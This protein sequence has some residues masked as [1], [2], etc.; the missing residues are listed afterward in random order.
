MEYL[1][2]STENY[3]SFTE[4]PSQTFEGVTVENL[5]DMTYTLI[6]VDLFGSFLIC[7]AIMA[8][9]LLRRIGT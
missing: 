6:N 7:G 5:T 2:E 9:A 4:P 3:D 8:T 1:P